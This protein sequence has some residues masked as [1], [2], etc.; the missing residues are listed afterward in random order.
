MKKGGIVLFAL[1]CEV[2]ESQV[3]PCPVNHGEA[4]ATIAFVVVSPRISSSM[5]RQDTIFDDPP[6]IE[7][8]FNTCRTDADEV[9]SLKR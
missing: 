6:G 2:M 1:S 5:K 3:A 9:D 7:G 4:G 8:D